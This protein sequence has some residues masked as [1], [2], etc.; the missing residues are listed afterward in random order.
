MDK[1]TAAALIIGILIPAFISLAK[2][3]GL[4][5]WAN[6]LLTII[7]CVGAG[8]LTMYSAGELSWASWSG[9]NLLVT[10]GL[11]F[12]SSQAIYASFWKDSPVGQFI[13]VKSSFI[14]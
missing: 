9:P 5:R 1:V 14:K 3:I 6:M 7:V 10:I 12:A 4:P 11:I 13:E 8:L 2:Q